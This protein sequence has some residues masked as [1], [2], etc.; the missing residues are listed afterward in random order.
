M[1]SSLKPNS[2]TSSALPCGSAIVAARV[3]GLHWSCLSAWQDRLLGDDTPQWL[4]LDNDPHAELIKA[5]P[6]RRVYHVK[7]DSLDVY[8]KLYFAV[9][10]PDRLKW[11][12]RAAPGRIEF[13]HLQLAQQR[14]VP[15]PAPLA[16]AQ[17]S[18]N[19]T[20]VALLIT[21]S[22]GSLPSLARLLWHEKPA[23]DQL[24]PALRAAGQLVGLLHHAGIQHHDLHPG[25]ILLTPL[26]QSTDSAD[27]QAFITDLQ[28][29]SIRRDFN[30]SITSDPYLRRNIT[31]LTMILA[32]ISTAADPDL[33]RIFVRAYLQTIQPDQ[34]WPAR[35][36]DDYYQRLTL[37]ADR[38]IRRTWRRR[39]R[40][41]LRDSR[42]SRRIRLPDHWQARVFCQTKHPLPDSP[43]SNCTFT[44][45]QWQPTLRDPLTL[46]QPGRTLKQTANTTVIAKQIELSNT[47]LQVVAKQRHLRRGWRGCLQGLRRSRALNQWYHAHA[48]VTRGIRTPWPL[49]AIEQRCGL[50][51][52]Q[53][54]FLCE[55]IP[56]CHNLKL[57]IENNS[58]HLPTPSPARTQLARQLGQLLGQL[59]TL[60]FR[61]R[62]CKA[63]NIVIQIR[64]DQ[65]DTCI[66]YL[67]DLD[68]LRLRR[69]P[70]KYNHHEAIVRL[71]ASLQKFQQVTLRDYAA[72][73][74][75]YLRHIDTHQ[76]RDRMIRR[77]LWQK[78][79]RQVTLRAGRQPS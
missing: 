43:A 41:A 33:Q 30:Q 66:P 9:G 27:V 22:L 34:Q 25:N 60:G 2:R 52:R 13:D 48:L 12:I 75:A 46:L 8:A 79:S 6:V 67:V 63:S 74:N 23:P 57:M 24:T 32:A 71:A 21:E 61:H 31:N 72:G 1:K 65:P 14:S 42:Y 39:D 29:V 36:F 53:N 7:N 38:H 62:D 35:Q 5:S 18:I 37:L 59:R 11:L 45:D 26:G 28:N 51:L 55:E 44:P 69:C 16:W 54:I 56:N 49:A 47:T 58:E 4:D 68:G 40:R 17:G 19:G 15:A 73:F 78:L 70:S 77:R 76:Y 20:P 50:L 64:P 3:H 10:L